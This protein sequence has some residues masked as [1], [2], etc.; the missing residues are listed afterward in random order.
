MRAMRAKG[1]SGCDDLELIVRF[2]A[3]PIYPSDEMQPQRTS[4]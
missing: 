2:E 3:T 4:V 1:F